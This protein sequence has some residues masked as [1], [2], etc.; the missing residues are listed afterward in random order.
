M[1]GE[2]RYRQRLGTLAANWRVL[3]LR[4]LVALIFGLVVLFWP[5][6][7][8]AVLTLLSGLY[9]LVDGGFV[10]VPAIRSSER[11]A[12]RWLPLAEGAVGVTAGLLALLWPGMTVSGLLY[13]ITG[14]ALLTGVLKITTAIALRS[15]VENEWLLAGSGALSVLFGLLLAALAG[16]DLPS[17]APFIGV[18]AIV[19]GLAMI[20]FAFRNRDRQRTRRAFRAIPR[21]G[22]CVAKVPS[23]RPSRVYGVEGRPL[24]LLST[25]PYGNEARILRSRHLRSPGFLR[26]PRKTRD[27]TGPLCGAPKMDAT[28]E[29]GP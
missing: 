19:V 17:L 1:S 10:L 20:V 29:A 16:S 3:A 2:G 4:G 26:E 15:E 24:C 12:R 21:S 8:L 7:V 27:R 5:G 11:G 23:A 9:A 28:G 25:L 18:F 14:W 22:C 6:L 13:V